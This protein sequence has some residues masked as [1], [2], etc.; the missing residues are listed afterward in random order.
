M[1]NWIFNG[2]KFISKTSASI[3]IQRRINNVKMNLFF[4][5]IYT[6]KS[7]KRELLNSNTV[8]Q[9]FVRYLPKQIEST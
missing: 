2:V 7:N 1:F 9:I 8:S 6:D 3:S 5:T 4:S